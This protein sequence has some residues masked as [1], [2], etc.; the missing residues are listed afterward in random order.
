M[1]GYRTNPRSPG[2]LRL[3]VVACAT[4][5]GAGIW[6]VTTVHGA[7]PVSPADKSCA[8]PSAPGDSDACTVTVDTTGTGFFPPNTTFVLT[9]TGPAGAT[10]TD[11][12]ANTAV[13]HLTAAFTATTCTLQVVSVA[14]PGTVL[15]TEVIHIAPGTATGAKVAQT[16]TFTGFPAFDVPVSGAGATVT[17]AT[18]T[19]TPK[20]TPTPKPKGKVKAVVVP[21]T[22]GGDGS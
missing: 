15:A 9:L 7:T 4:L 21:G 18:A 3:A 10:F 14:A 20:P 2:L 5:A 11:C 12:K 13:D 6:A 1:R 19:A 22:G 17:A 8:G 16:L